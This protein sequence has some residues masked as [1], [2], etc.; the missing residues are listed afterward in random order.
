[1]R[2]VSKKFTNRRQGD[3]ESIALDRELLKKIVEDMRNNAGFLSPL[4]HWHLVEKNENT[5]ALEVPESSVADLY[6][7]S[8]NA[9][10]SSAEKMLDA[11]IGCTGMNSLSREELE[12]E[13]DFIKNIDILE[14]SK[15]MRE[16]GFENF[17]Y[18]IRDKDT[19]ADI[20]MIYASLE[21]TPDTGGSKLVL[22]LGGGYGR[23]AESMMNVAEG[24]KYVMIDAVPGSLLYAYKYLKKM[25]PDKK[26][27]FYY[28]D[29]NFDLDQ[30]DVYILPSWH[31]ESK[32]IYKYDCCI[33]IASME[34]MGQEHVDYYLDLFD[35]VLVENGIAYIQNAHDYVFKGEWK[36]KNNWERVLM[37][38]SP[39]SWTE[40]FP[41]EIFR[42]GNKDYTGWNR[43]ILAGY[44]YALYE[45]RTLKDKMEKMQNEIWRL[46]YAES[47][48]EKCRKEIE[49]LQI[50][51]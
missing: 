36:F 40:Y 4:N 8:M 9:Q 26:I 48:L 20:N 17:D 29:E 25:L 3:F 50:K 42:K 44:E 32:N 46:Q 41:T 1:M 2:I 47:E 6:D 34:E 21:Q 33:N 37:Y 10:Y 51:I 12:Q 5:N 18:K 24:I 30:Y 22:E 23:I 15:Y 28:V 13:N 11:W 14:I 45:K 16:Q 38:N 27:G 19:V 35:R 49:V 43:C 7:Q 31:F 39:A